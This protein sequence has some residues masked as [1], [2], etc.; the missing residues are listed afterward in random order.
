MEKSIATF[1]VTA[2]LT[3]L[4]CLIAFGIGYGMGCLSETRSAE[5]GADVSVKYEQGMMIIHANSSDGK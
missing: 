2:L 3:A 4:L 1:P 5:L